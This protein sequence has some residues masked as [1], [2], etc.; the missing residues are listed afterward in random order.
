MNTANKITILR[1]ILIPVFMLLLATN[2]VWGRVAALIVFIIASV[3]DSIDGHI[4]RKYNQIT[5]FGK[6]MDPLA[7]KL[8]ITSALVMFV[9]QG[10]VSAWVTVIIV[11]RELAVTGFRM[12]AAS[13]GRVIAAS[14]WGKAKTVTQIIAVVAALVFTLDLSAF[15]LPDLMPVVTV[16]MWL[17]ALIT[18]VSGIDYIVKNRDVLKNNADK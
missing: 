5:N 1:I 13:S 4:A 2:A 8:L 10:T 12:I 17:A 14:I 18:L 11:A 16:L 15:G 3:T 6:F 9:E 7:D